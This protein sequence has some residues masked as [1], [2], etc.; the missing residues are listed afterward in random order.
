[1]NEPP[2]IIET[3]G[4]FLVLYILLAL[5]GVAMQIVILFLIIRFAV[6]S[7]LRAHFSQGQ[8]PP[9]SLGA[10]ITLGHLHPNQ[11]PY[12]NQQQQRYG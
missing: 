1:M 5:F 12:G 6:L 4:G 10:P 8:P 9:A 2:G 3:V 11:Y 7:A